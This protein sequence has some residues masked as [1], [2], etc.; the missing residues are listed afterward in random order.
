M[1]PQRVHPDEH[2]IYASGKQM[3]RPAIALAYS[4]QG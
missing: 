3:Q 1:I 4:L 2:N